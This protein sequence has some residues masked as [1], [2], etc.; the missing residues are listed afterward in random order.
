MIRNIFLLTVVLFL[1]ACSMT[2][3]GRFENANEHVLETALYVYEARSD[4]KISA[5][6]AVIYQEE[7]ESAYTLTEAG[8]VLCDSDDAAAAEKFEE[9]ENILDTIDDAL[10]ALEDDIVSSDKN[11]VNQVQVN[12]VQGE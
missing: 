7:I 10:D 4:G 6:Q 3:S 5:D 1:G 12:Q 8:S 9:S 2:C 11:Q